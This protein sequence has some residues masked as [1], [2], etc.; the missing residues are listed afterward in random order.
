MTDT[1][2]HI[3]ARLLKGLGDVVR[4]IE[5]KDPQLAAEVQK[6]HHQVV[7]DTFNMVELLADGTQLREAQEQAVRA[8]KSY[9]S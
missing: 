3:R 9:R 6:R 1:H 7:T 5:E 4:Y 8:Y 2:R